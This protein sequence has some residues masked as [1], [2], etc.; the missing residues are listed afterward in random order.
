MA[1]AYVLAV[2]SKAGMNYPFPAN[3]YGI[4]LYVRTIETTERQYFDAGVQIDFQ[5]KS[6]T[7]ANLT[8]DAVYYD[9]E[10][11]TYNDFRQSR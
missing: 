2:V 10:I 6:T 8:E 7:R 5:I 3:D 1:R 11:K 9:L 4:D